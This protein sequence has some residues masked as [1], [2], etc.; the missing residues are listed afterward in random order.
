MIIALLGKVPI[1]ASKTRWIRAKFMNEFVKI[2]GKDDIAVVRKANRDMDYAFPEFMY[3]NAPMSVWWQSLYN[4]F[5]EYQFILIDKDSREL[6]ALGNCLPL[7]WDSPLEELPEEGI[8]WA[9]RTAYEQ[10]K[11]GI[12]PNILSAYQIIVSREARGKG[13]SR[14]AVET[15]IGE[16]RSHGLTKLIAPVRPNRKADFPLI[17]IDD[18]MRWERSDGLPFDDWLRVHVRLGGT[19]IK[20]CHKSYLVKGTIEDWRKWTGQEFPGSG[21]YVVPGGL[22]PTVISKET[23]TGI[24]FEPNIWTVHE[25]R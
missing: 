10:H 12:K 5:A 23:D 6:M 4:E 13:I 22:V 24:Y 3:N 16:A 11:A 19:I 25:I 20:V 2:S 18:Y 17:S 9:S 15:M 21:Q 14:I 7:F 1:S 8:E